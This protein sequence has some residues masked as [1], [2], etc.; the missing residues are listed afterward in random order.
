MLWE[1]FATFL[2]IGFVSVGGGYS[3][4]PVIEHEA[5]SRGWMNAESFSDM[6]AVAGA[7]PGPIATNTAIMVGYE[8]DGWLG[9]AVSAIAMTLP[10]LLIV[11]VVGLLFAKFH[12]HPTVESAFYGLRP[13]VAALILY[14]AYRMLMTGGAAFAFDWKTACFLAIFAGAFLALMRYRVHPLAVIAVS[15]LVGV[16]LYA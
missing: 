8:A 1:L 11:I 9:A 3:M 6:I 12:H 10:S 15:G 2:M 14:A 5:I 7:S 16:A 13:I 4:I